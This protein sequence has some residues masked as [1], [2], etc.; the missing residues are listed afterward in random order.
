[1]SYM[2]APRA[3]LLSVAS[4]VGADAILTDNSAFL[5]H[6]Q[7]GCTSGVAIALLI[8]FSVRIL[9]F[10]TIV[11]IQH[12]ASAGI[13]A[14]ILRLLLIV[15]GGGKRDQYVQSSKSKGGKGGKGSKGKGKGKGAG[16]GKGGNGVGRSN[17]RDMKGGPSEQSRKSLWLVPRGSIVFFRSKSTAGPG[18][19][20]ESETKR[21]RLGRCCSAPYRFLRW[22]MLEHMVR[23]RRRT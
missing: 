5:R 23:R 13:I 2:E 4:Y 8:L 3:A 22:T 16:N 15:L 6:L 21:G 10:T 17:S 11:W 12:T 1:M 19:E 14:S 18:G 20:T 9:T 7:E